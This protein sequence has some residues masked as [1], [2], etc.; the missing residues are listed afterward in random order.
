MII[1]P[2]TK[3]IDLGNSAVLSS[4]DLT[5]QIRGLAHGLLNLNLPAGS[6]V[7]IVGPN[8]IDYVVT[9]LALRITNLIAV[10]INYKLPSNVLV[11]CFG[12]VELILGNVEYK[13]ILPNIPFIEFGGQLNSIVSD[14]VDIPDFAADRDS[15]ILFTS[16]SSGKPKPVIY[17]TADRDGSIGDNNNK[18]GN[19]VKTLSPNP[20]FH[21]AGLTWLDYNALYGNHLF[22]APTHNPQMLADTI[23][24][25]KIN[26]LSIIGSVMQSLLAA[27]DSLDSVNFDSVSF[28]SLPSTPVSACTVD[29]IKRYFKNVV[30]IG[31][32]Y[33]LTETGCRVFD[34]H[35]TLPTPLGSVGIPSV[36][37]DCKL[38]DGQLHIKSN[39][40]LSN[41]KYSDREYFNTQ[42]YFQV[43]QQGFYYYMG[44]SDDMFK[45]NG[46]KVYPRDIESVLETHP[47]VNSAVALGFDDLK[48]GHRPCAFVTT[49]GAVATS[50]LVEYAAAKLARHQ[51]PQTIWIIDTVPLATTGKVDRTTLYNLGKTYLNE[52]QSYN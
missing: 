33:G 47:Q 49:S 22:I 17:S 45:V 37:F 43:D 27:V 16:G 5:K 2:Q 15:L 36:K 12:N 40:L 14:N 31:N 8:S 23:R 46:E 3:L 48:L 25:Y 10:P 26:N 41:K 28:I 7:G 18:S 4:L 13:N 29:R 51:V 42:D 38:I 11:E 1:H 50:E 44:R 20:M 19:S 6:L 35:P 32:P 34:T 9:V 39:T 30:Y 24:K 52:S 21:L